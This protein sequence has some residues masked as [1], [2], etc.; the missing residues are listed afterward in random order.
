MHFVFFFEK[1]RVFNFVQGIENYAEAFKPYK[2]LKHL[3]LF[4]FWCLQHFWTPKSFMCFFRGFSLKDASLTRKEEFFLKQAKIILASHL[5]SQNG[6]PCIKDKR[7]GYLRSALLLAEGF[8]EQT[9]MRSSFKYYF[10]YNTSLFR[11]KLKRVLLLFYCLL[12][13]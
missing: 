3:L 10:Y 8:L 11:S 12:T 1:K 4:K 7:V 5:A 2:G 6:L 9:L 13:C